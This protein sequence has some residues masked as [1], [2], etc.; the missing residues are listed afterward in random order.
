M[1]VS[2]YR[3]FVPIT[4]AW[5]VPD[6]NRVPLVSLAYSYFIFF[7]LFNLARLSSG[8]YLLIFLRQSAPAFLS[9]LQSLFTLD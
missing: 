4:V 1:G 6:L 2:G 7:V 5:A 8:V 9:S 3:G